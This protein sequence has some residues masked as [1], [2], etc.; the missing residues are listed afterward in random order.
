MFVFNKLDEY[1][2]EEKPIIIFLSHT[3]LDH[4][5]GLHI[6]NKFR[7][8]QGIKIYGETGIKSALNTII[9]HPYTAPF[10]NVP[11]SI[12]IIEFEEGENTKPFKFKAKH[13]VHSD[14]CIGYRIELDNKTI[15]YCIDTS[16]CDNIFELSQQAD[17]LILECSYKSGQEK[18]GWPHLKPE[19]AAEIAKQ[20][21]VKQLILTHFDASIYKNIKDREEVE[22]KAKDIFPSTIAAKDGLQLIV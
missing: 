19:E 12:E 18:W 2:I 11:Y 9:T 3:H 8:P 10:K 22:L 15:T 1:I 20:C 6:L 21:D 4:V 14:S 13:L 16:V 5:I 7:F 17:L